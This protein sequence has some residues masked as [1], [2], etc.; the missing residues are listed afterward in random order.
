M[1]HK[2]IIATTQR[3]DGRHHPIAVQTNIEIPFREMPTLEEIQV[4]LKRFVQQRDWEQYHS[5]K[6]LAMALAGEAAEILEIFQWLTEEQSRKLGREDL[7]ALKDEL[8]DTFIYLLE[9]AGS[10]QIDLLAAVQNKI[11]KNALKYPR[12]KAKGSAKKYTRL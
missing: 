5:P 1:D 12:E 2:K 8:A 6:N 9:I 3:F 11:R 10:F 4:K 7:E